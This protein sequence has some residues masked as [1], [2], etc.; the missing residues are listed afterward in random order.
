MVLKLNTALKM[1]VFFILV[2]ELLILKLMRIVKFIFLIK[3]VKRFSLVIKIATRININTIIPQAVPS[4]FSLH[5]LIKKSVTALRLFG[6]LTVDGILVRSLII[7]I[8]LLYL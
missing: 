8:F 5:S 3:V 7:P 1:R 2:Q 6:S 4:G